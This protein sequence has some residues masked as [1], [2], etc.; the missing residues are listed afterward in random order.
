[1]D[2]TFE[3]EMAVKKGRGSDIEIDDEEL[4]MRSSSSLI[5]NELAGKDEPIDPIDQVMTVDIPE[6]MR[7]GR[8]RPRWAQ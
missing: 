2:V 7:V 3:E 6:D 5:Q 4:E 8:K 1:M